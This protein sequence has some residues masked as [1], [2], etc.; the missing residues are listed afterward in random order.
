MKI[1][2]LEE[3][4]ATPEVMAAWQALPSDR[5][6]LAVGLSG[7]PDIAP[8][9]YD[10][11]DRRIA[12]MDAMGVDVQVL[13]LTTPAV[14]TLDRDDAVAFARRCNDLV[15]ATAR[16]RP[17]RFQGFATLPLQDPAEA[18]RELERAVRDLGLNGAMLHGGTPGKTL[19]HPDFLPVFETAA[20][21]RAP[22]YLHPNSPPPGVREAY[23]DGLGEALSTRLATAGI[24]WHY[25]DGMQALRLVLAGVFDRLPDL[26]LILGHWGEVV[27][28]Y[29][30]RIALLD[31]QAKLDRPIAAYFGSN[32]SV[33]GSGLFS[34]R[35]LRWAVEVLGVDRVLF[36]V[37]Y[38]FVT[39]GADECRRFL[40]GSGLTA[41]DQEAVGSGNWDRLCAR[42]R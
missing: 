11:A 15:A 14:Q 4:Y 35:Y 12:A 16:A 42:A 38:P 27:L 20:A 24:G 6:D 37:D 18:A 28:F 7:T 13:S 34:H 8:R 40:A 22:V 26:Q 10:L 23:Y 9:L 41:T 3:H 30:D 2:A 21:L 29:L 33:T 19:D 5:R 17:D 39:P 31:E 36:S 25:Q 1:V 32:M